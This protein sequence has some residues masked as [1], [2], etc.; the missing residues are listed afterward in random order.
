MDYPQWFVDRGIIDPS[1]EAHDHGPVNQGQVKWIASQTYA[2]FQ[3]KLPSADLDK[4]LLAVDSFPEGSNH[5]P[6]NL[7]MLKAVATPFYD[8]LIAAG[9]ETGYP[10]EGGSPADYN[11]ANQGQLKNL[12]AFNLDV[13]LD[14]DGLLDWWAEQYGL[15]SS[16]ANGDT[17][18]DGLTNLQ[19]YQAGTDPNNTDSDGDGVSDGEEAALGTDPLAVDT[20]NDGL[21]DGEEAAL[22]TDPLAVDTDGDGLSDGEEVN[23]FGSNP[24]VP[25]WQ[26]GGIAGM[27]QVERWNGIGGTH[28][29][30]LV[31]SSRFG[32]EPDERSWVATTEY[33][34][35]SG[36]NY[37]IRMRGTITVPVDGTYTFWLTADDSAQVWL[38]DTE[39]PYRRKLIL[40]LESWT[41]YRDLTNPKVHG[42]PVMLTSNQTCYVEILLKEGGGG[43]HVTLWWTRPGETEPEI[44]GS[45][46]L[47]SYVQPADDQ[48]MDGLPDTWETAN[49]LDPLDGTGGGYQDADGDLYS[50][51]AEYQLGLSPVVVDADGDGLKDGD[52]VTITLTDHNNA[53]SDADGTPDRVVVDSVNG[54]DTF[55]R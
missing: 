32:N 1:Q 43:D 7:G 11:L 13:D 26:D 49:G 23:T 35:N 8:E 21:S 30:S 47:H 22:G 54:A 4:L 45:E 33:P 16:G 40:D 9:Y 50:D 27:L 39:S 3:Q 28:I 29:L 36:D 42:I 20:D 31:G 37:G 55:S 51:F 41:S 24:T 14:G 15:G 53:D 18:G 34:N 19:E 48:D 6:A 38:G 17:D 46:Y 10:W 5:K 2:E 25:A 44:I 12:F 52:E